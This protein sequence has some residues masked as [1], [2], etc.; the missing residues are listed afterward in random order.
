M[1]TERYDTRHA[2]CTFRCA[3]FAPNAFLV[4]RWEGQEAV[5]RP[6]RFE[7]EV[8]CA[9]HDIALPLLLGARATLETYSPEGKPLPWHGVITQVSHTGLDED[10]A[11]YRVVLEPQ[12]A[13]LS[14][15]RASRVYVDS[16]EPGQPWPDLAYLI[17]R[18]LRLCQLTDEARPCRRRT[19]CIGAIAFRHPGV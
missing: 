7:I 2:L 13:L 6:Y 9:D 17:R 19:R 16:D 12:L 18:T 14:Q 15:F 11:F 1:L 3:G 8:A 10:Y 4:S 5:S